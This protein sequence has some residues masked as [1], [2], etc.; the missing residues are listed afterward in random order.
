MRRFTVYR[1]GDLSATHNSDKVNPPD[2]P[3]FEGIVFSDGACVVRW[4]TNSHSTTVWNSFEE[5]WRVHGHTEPGS[6]HGTEIVWHDE[7]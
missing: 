4:L 5:M 6:K 3:Q 1:H 7:D 2:Q